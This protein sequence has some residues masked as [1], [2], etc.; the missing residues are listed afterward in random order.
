MW[1]RPLTR[2]ISSQTRDRRWI[3]SLSRLVNSSRPDSCIGDDMSMKGR[4]TLSVTSLQTNG[5]G[6]SPSALVD[7]WCEAL[8]HLIVDVFCIPET[9]LAP[10]W[11]HSMVETLFLQKGYHTISHN[12]PAVTPADPQ[13]NSSGIIIGVPAS[14][15]GGLSLPRKDEYGRAIAACVPYA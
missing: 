5:A 10:D 6:G 4:N 12:R 8:G 13:Y 14:T 2:M 15:P 1:M 9:R 3:D 7:G 11:K